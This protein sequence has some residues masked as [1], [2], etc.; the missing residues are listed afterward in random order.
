MAN[1]RRFREGMTAAGF[2][3]QA[4]RP[5]HRARSCSATRA[6]PRTW[7]RDLLDEGIYVDRLLLSRWCPK[8]EARI[9]VQL[10]AAHTPE[11][12]DRAVAAF[13]KVGRRR[14]VVPA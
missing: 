9:R 2:Q 12:V 1:T 3:H 7:P 6:W 5:P 10:S 4:R 13:V 14:G 11:M 8:G